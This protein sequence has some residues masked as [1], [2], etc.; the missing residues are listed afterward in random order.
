MGQLFSIKPWMSQ[1]WGQTG[2][3]ILFVVACMYFYNKSTVEKKKE[4]A[5]LAISLWLM[6]YSNTAIKISGMVGYYSEWY[7]MFWI[8]PV[9]P[10]V[11]SSFINFV[12]DQKDTV[13]KL[14]AIFL[15]LMVMAATSVDG[16]ENMSFSEIDTEYGIKAEN[17]SI[18][19]IIKADGRAEEPHV[20]CEQQVGI[21]IRLYDPSI[22]YSISRY[23]HYYINERGLDF[24]YRTVGPIDDK[25]ALAKVV[26]AGRALEEKELVGA[27][28]AEGVDYLV[29]KNS[30]SNWEY[31]ESMGI[32]FCG[33]TTNYNIYYCGMHK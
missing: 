6:C 17:I 7:R 16:T 26:I 21:E 28:R 13:S 3:A 1:Y 11:A 20:A 23:T 19:K 30:K 24:D 5:L 33:A 12:G 8:L 27:I 18:A 15:I 14:G 9:I 2:F 31:F 22:F 25:M 10:V 29:V 32:E 4:M